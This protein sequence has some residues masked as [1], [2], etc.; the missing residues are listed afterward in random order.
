MEKWKVT[1]VMSKENFLN[2]IKYL[3]ETIKQFGGLVIIIL[4]NIFFFFCFKYY[5]WWR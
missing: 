3:P 4:N 1:R 2:K 5:V